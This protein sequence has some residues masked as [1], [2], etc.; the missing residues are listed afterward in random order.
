MQ[1]QFSLLS[2]EIPLKKLL[3]R[4]RD[5]IRS[6]LFFSFRVD[7]METSAFLAILSSPFLHFADCAH[8]S[9]F[10][11]ELLMWHWVLWMLY[12]DLF[13]LFMAG[14]D[15]LGISI[16][17]PW[18]RTWFDKDG[19]VSRGLCGS[20][21]TISRHV[22]TPYSRLWLIERLS[23]PSFYVELALW[24][25]FWKRSFKHKS[26]LVGKV[27]KINKLLW[28]FLISKTDCFLIL[29]SALSDVCDLSV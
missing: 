9:D 17:K 1:I 22:C 7:W 24:R 14:N 10:H 28:A 11:R 23:L 5:V 12:G 26:T 4:V 27:S 21:G 25:L 20:Y 15:V 29:I 6:S 13:G 3:E 16:S 8:F 18:M 2:A 19:W